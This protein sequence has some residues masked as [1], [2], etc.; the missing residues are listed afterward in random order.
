LRD[1]ILDV[2]DKE[3]TEKLRQSILSKVFSGQL[4]GTE[5]E[6]LRLNFT[7]LPDNRILLELKRNKFRVLGSTLIICNIYNYR[8]ISRQGDIRA[9]KIL[10][11]P[12]IS[13]FPVHML[14]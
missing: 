1:D 13:E 2:S 14:Q 10:L 6:I 4:V 12:A 11:K 3:K 7:I 9:E 8:G 5:A